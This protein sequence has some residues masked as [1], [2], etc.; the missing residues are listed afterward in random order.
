MLQEN[1]QELVDK[2]QQEQQVCLNVKVEIRMIQQRPTEVSAGTIE[3]LLWSTGKI[4]RYSDPQVQWAIQILLW[5]MG[6]IQDLA[7][8]QQYQ[9]HLRESVIALMNMIK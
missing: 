4:S 2:I 9:Q 6:T 8:I 1:N 7:L 5:S 3:S